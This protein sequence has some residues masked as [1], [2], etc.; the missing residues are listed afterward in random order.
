M[1][2]GPLP[3]IAPWQGLG[4]PGKAPIGQ[5]AG[6]GIGRERQSRCGSGRSRARR[7]AAGGDRPVG[8]HLACGVLDLRATGGATPFR[9][10]C[11]WP[12]G[13]APGRFD[14]GG[15][16]L[17]GDVKVALGDADRRVELMRGPAC[18]PARTGRPAPPSSPAPVPGS[19]PSGFPSSGAL[20]NNAFAYTGR[21]VQTVLAASPARHLRTRPY[22]PQTNPLP[23]F[24]QPEP[25]PLGARERS[26]ALLLP[27]ADGNNLMRSDT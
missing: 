3:G 18:S 23:G 15:A 24:L 6:P 26:S 5:P 12:D 21:A 11:Q 20:T 19:R 14:A 4:D 16:A 22:R 13:P 17:T 25:P 9:H 1:S 7:P 8:G 2:S 27:Q 10:P